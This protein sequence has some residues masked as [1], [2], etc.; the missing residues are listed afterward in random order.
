M[1]QN[2]GIAKKCFGPFDEI[3]T[4]NV[5]KSFAAR[6]SNAVNCGLQNGGNEGTASGSETDRHN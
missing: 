4:P 1:T 5:R 6:V 2:N 3:C